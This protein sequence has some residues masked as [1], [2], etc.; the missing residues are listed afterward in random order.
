MHAYICKS[1]FKYAFLC[2]DTQFQD[3]QMKENAWY[4]SFCTYFS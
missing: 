4:L 1:I 3:T 2:I